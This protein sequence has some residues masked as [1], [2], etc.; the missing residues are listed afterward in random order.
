MHA[1]S[2]LKSLRRCLQGKG[3][4]MSEGKGKAKP[5]EFATAQQR[6]NTRPA[7]LRAL[8]PTA[9]ATAAMRVNCA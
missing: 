2:E 3:E 5:A 1:P 9:V 4:G 8:A 6:Q 7:G